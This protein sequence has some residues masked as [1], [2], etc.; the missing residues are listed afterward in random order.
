MKDDKI[1]KLMQKHDFKAYTENTVKNIEQ[2]MVKVKET[3][4][5]GF[6]ESWEDVSHGVASFGAPVRD[7]SC[8]VIGAI[9]VG[10]LISRFVGEKEKYWID[11]VKDI[12]QNISDKLGFIRK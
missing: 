1:L 2:L 8:K 11:V 10:G 6:S 5:Q 9:S 7:S 12:A 3:R 4:K